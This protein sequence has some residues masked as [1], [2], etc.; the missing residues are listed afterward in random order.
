MLLED[1]KRTSTNLK[2]SNWIT[3]MAKKRK[4]A[5][6]LIKKETSDEAFHN[7]LIDQILNNIKNRFRFCLPSFHLIKTFMLLC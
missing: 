7:N 1:E 5:K 2:K 3:K 4:D 6:N